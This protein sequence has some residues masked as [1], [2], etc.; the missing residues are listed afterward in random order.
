VLFRRFSWEEDY[1]GPQMDPLDDSY[2]I[3]PLNIDKPVP[4]KPPEEHGTGEHVR[5]GG[6]FK[7]RR[8]PLNTTRV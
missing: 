3:K 8:K 4:V 7:V 6:A 1:Y 2:G 5:L